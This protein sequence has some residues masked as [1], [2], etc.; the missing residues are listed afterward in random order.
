MFMF[1]QPQDGHVFH[2]CHKNAFAF[3][4]MLWLFLSLVGCSTSRKEYV[5]DYSRGN[6]ATAQGS[7]E[8]PCQTEGQCRML[9][10]RDG[11]RS[12]WMVYQ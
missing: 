7:R 4:A 2:A 5:V 11:V 3:G 10:E 8:R 12:Y 9:A 1:M 6:D